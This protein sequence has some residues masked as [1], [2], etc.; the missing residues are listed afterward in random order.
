MNECNPIQSNPI[1]SLDRSKAF[2]VVVHYILAI[3]IPILA[4]NSLTLENRQPSVDLRDPWLRARCKG[5]GA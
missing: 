5:K 1:Q 4:Q 3:E 2:D